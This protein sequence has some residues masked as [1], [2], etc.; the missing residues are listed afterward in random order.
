MLTQK[1]CDLMNN[2][3]PCCIRMAA[4]FFGTIIL[5][6]DGSVSLI[7]SSYAVLFCKIE[8]TCVICRHAYPSKGMRILS[9][10]A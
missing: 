6:N 2:E 1:V 4:S 3:K 8:L 9:T 7:S 5:Q 10:A